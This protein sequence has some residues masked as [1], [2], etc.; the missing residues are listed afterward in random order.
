MLNKSSLKNNI[1]LSLE[2]C[3]NNDNDDSMPNISKTF[4]KALALNIDSY[5]KQAQ[6]SPMTILANGDIKALENKLIIPLFEGLSQ[7]L[8]LYW[9]K[10]VFGGSG[11]VPINPVLQ[12]TMLSAGSILTLKIKS[13]MNEI[14]D[15]IE[16]FAVKLS[17]EI[18]IY[19]TSLQVNA[20][21]TS[22]PPVI[23]NIPIS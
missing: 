13:F 1:Q 15:S 17:N 4:A 9:S 6:A 20:T 12:T 18:H 22:T 14:S 3:L 10:V 7:G 2:N 5:S 21:T 16:S 23:A 19:T 8:N 11:F